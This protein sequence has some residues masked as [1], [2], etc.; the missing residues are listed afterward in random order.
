MKKLL[1]IGLGALSLSSASA[2]PPVGP[3]CAGFFFNQDGSWSPTHIFVFSTPTS[4][5]QIMP[6][7][8][9]RPQ[10]PGAQGWLARYLNARCRSE[11]PNGGVGHIPLVP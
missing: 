7:D 10:M 8:K 9:M 3:N 5:T 4:Q 2:E 1:L 6:S 11:R